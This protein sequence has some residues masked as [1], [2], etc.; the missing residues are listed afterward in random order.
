[1]EKILII[2]TAFIG[3]VVLATS[4]IE[5]VKKNRPYGEIHFLLRK[6]NEALL[7]NNPHIEK[8]WIWDKKKKYTSLFSLMKEM[9]K[10]RFS[11]IF[12]IQRYF[13]SGLMSFLLKSSYKSSFDKNPLSFFSDRV[14]PHKM[15][16][17]EE[18][19]YIIHEVERNETLLPKSWVKSEKGLRERPR[20]YFKEERQR[21]EN[22]IILAPCSVWK[23]K[24]WPHEKWKSLAKSLLK[25]GWEVHFVGGPADFDICENIVKSDNR[26]IFNHCGKL[27]LYE[28][29]DLMREGTR[30]VANDSGT[31]HLA[32]SV[33]APSTGIFCSTT[34]NFGFFGLSDDSILLEVEGLDCKPC[35]LH[36]KKDCPEKHFRCGK[37]LEVEKVLETIDKMPIG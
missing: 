1:M 7:T 3:D 28:S 37:D 14:L 19:G 35:G 16:W 25:R 32:S 29:A 8:V 9:R 11:Y 36:G 10:I 13:N 6:G 21:K 15:P 5:T 33:N 30:V 12:N 34:K 4:L 2:Q 17:V 20:I 31:L 22:M 27:S 18:S 26:K 23:T 24:E